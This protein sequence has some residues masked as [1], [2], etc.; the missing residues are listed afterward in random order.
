[1]SSVLQSP[2]A[3]AASSSMLSL[4]LLCSSTI[5]HSLFLGLLHCTLA[6][7][8]CS[9]FCLF[10]NHMTSNDHLFAFETKCPKVLELSELDFQ[11]LCFAGPEHISQG[12]VTIC[13]SPVLVESTELERSEMMTSQRHVPYHTY[14]ANIFALQ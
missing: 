2:W 6:N 14:S 1:M 13:S 4:T 9:A 8:V 5:L 11:F 12:L 7:F 3:A 10:H